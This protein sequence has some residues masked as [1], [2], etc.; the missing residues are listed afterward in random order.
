MHL[1]LDGHEVIEADMGIK[2]LELIKSEK[3]EVV[4][5][6]V[7]MPEMDGLEV[8]Q[9]IR[10]DPATSH[11][12]VIMLSAKDQSIDKVSGL[13]TGADAYMTK[14]FEPDE[15]KAQVRA[16]LR[17]VK[18]RLDALIDPLTGLFNR[19]AFNKFLERE[20]ALQSRYDLELSMAMIDLDHFKG[21]N[22][23]H[24]HDAGDD[25]LREVSGLLQD[26]CR[27][28]DLPCRWGGEE[29]V[30]LMPKTNEEG[31]LVATE[32]LRKLVEAQDFQQAGKLTVSIGLTEARKDES[33]ESLCKRA[34]QALYQAKEGGRNQVKPYRWAKSTSSDDDIFI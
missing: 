20:L 1:T 30:W 13:D 31:A 22:D 8:C 28:T 6:D 16:G 34:D 19:R 17:I 7:M 11:L 9:H 33:P 25:V 29:F 24:G 12:Y 21:V 32:R 3:P 14:P 4:V 15:L 27:S 2:G 10:G 26:I 23:T 18:G 5:L